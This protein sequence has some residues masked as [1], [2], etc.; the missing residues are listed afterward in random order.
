MKDLVFNYNIKRAG[1]YNV[2]G[3]SVA[4]SNV[5]AILKPEVAE[6]FPNSTKEEWTGLYMDSEL[7]LVEK[8]KDMIKAKIITKAEAAKLL[9]LIDIYADDRATHA[10]DNSNID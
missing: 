5:N 2:Y 8:F 1:S 10:V 9:D 3:T 7:A 6:Y 4:F